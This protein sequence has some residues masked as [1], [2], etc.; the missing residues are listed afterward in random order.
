MNKNKE[1]NKFKDN[2]LTNKNKMNCLKIKSNKNKDY[3]LKK[4][5]KLVNKNYSSFKLK[6]ICNPN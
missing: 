4:K 5:N 6:K 3:Y 1:K 2:C